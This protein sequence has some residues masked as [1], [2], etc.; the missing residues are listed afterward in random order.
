MTNPPIPPALDSPHLPAS[1]LKAATTLMVALGLLAG[2]V[3]C[4]FPSREQRCSHGVWCLVHWA[5]LGYSV[6]KSHQAVEQKLS[7]H[8]A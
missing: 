1:L 2:L 8:S 5:L 7:A 4:A 3:H 6:S